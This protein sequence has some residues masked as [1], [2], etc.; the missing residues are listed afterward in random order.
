MS[1]ERIVR[2]AFCKRPEFRRIFWRDALSSIQAVDLETRHDKQTCEAF[3]VSLYI[4]T[5][6]HRIK[7]AKIDSKFIIAPRWRRLCDE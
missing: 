3:Y 2:K 4:S 6:E 5:L 1:N 7:T